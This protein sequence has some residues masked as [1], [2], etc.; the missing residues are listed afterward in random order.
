MATIKLAVNP[1]EIIAQSKA[2]IDTGKN[3]DHFEVLAHSIVLAL[4]DSVESAST[5]M[6]RVDELIKEVENNVGDVPEAYQLVYFNGHSEVSIFALSKHIRQIMLVSGAKSKPPKPEYPELKKMITKLCQRKKTKNKEEVLYNTAPTETSEDKNSLVIK[7]DATALINKAETLL[8]SSN[9]ADIVVGIALLTGRRQVESAVYIKFK[10]EKEYSL[11]ITEPAKKRGS[12]VKSIWEIPCLTQSD[13]VEEATE[14]L[15]QLASFPTYDF[16]INFG[17]DRKAKEAFNNSYKKPILDSY[18][19]HIRP[20][21]DPRA[22]V[23]YETCFRELRSIYGAIVRMTKRLQYAQD[24]EKHLG[25]VAEFLQGAL[26]HKSANSTLHYAKWDVTNIPNKLLEEIPQYRYGM[27]GVEE[28]MNETKIIPVTFDLA[29]L[30]ELLGANIAAQRLFDEF[31]IARLKDPV[32]LSKALFNVFEQATSPNKKLPT[33]INP[34]TRKGDVVE[35]RVNEIIKQ[36]M[37]LNETNSLDKIYLNESFVQACYTYIYEKSLNFNLVK[38][39]L[40]E[41][42]PDGYNQKRGLTQSHN[43]RLRGAKIRDVYELI[44]TSL[45]AM[46]V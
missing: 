31:F 15:N 33:L 1:V 21:L 18:N 17:N 39:V 29:T 14:R 42:D 24:S 28:I 4:I 16:W 8:N 13:I 38:R 32:A 37:R 2:I 43:L 26:C 30:Q 41:Y 23:N 11:L 19:F 25:I 46:S 12:S 6:R 5:L 44:K 9:W 34:D 20:M 22:S 45:N 27:I 36:A 40:A 35:T 3:I 7:L 10:A